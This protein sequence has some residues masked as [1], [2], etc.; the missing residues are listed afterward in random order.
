MGDR[1]TKALALAAATAALL[2]TAAAARAGEV[3]DA[4]A[5]FD[6]AW[7]GTD[8]RE[9]A[10]AVERLVATG[11]QKAVEVVVSKAL[12]ADD[13]FVFERAVEALKEKTSET[14]KS[15]LCE[16]AHRHSN[17]DVRVTLVRLLGTLE[18]ADAVDGIARSFKDKEWTVRAAGVHAARERRSKELVR[19]LIALVESEDGRVKQDA[20]DA[21]R[22]L[23]GA[24][25][26]TKAKEWLDWWAT[27]EADF[28]LK[29]P[30]ADGAREVTK[31]VETMSREGL[32]EI[33]SKRTLFI[34][35]ISGSM[36]ARTQKGSRLEITKRE[37]KRV[38]GDLGPDMLFN[39]IFFSDKA[40]LW[41]PKMVKG[42]SEQK[43]AALRVVEAQKANGQTATFDA[44]RLAFGLD[45]VDT[46][47]FLSDGFPT[48]GPVTSE[49]LIKTEVRKWNRSKQITIHTIAFVAG[50]LKG[51]NEDKARAKSFMTELAAENGGTAKIIE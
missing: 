24:N 10:A 1:I 29:P 2:L 16:Q 25:Y 42:S 38:I 6:K 7:K 40:Q 33:R 47:Y 21:L 35:D 46:I 27:V 28:K 14:Q 49:E 22:D 20:A 41:K 17:K 44:L 51:E 12:L 5:A 30:L 11:E 37:L 4:I 8:Y 18:T 50:E 9:K 34:V 32:Y 31:D 19:P 36:E 43:S 48:V 26:G 23:T 15:W 13:Q 3:D 39:L 45:D